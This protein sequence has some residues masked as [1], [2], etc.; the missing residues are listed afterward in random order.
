M[1]REPRRSRRLPRRRSRPLLLVVCGSER[2]EA[3]YF[4]GLRDSGVTRAIDI[5]IVCR[6]KAP[7]QVVAYAH[8]YERNARRDFDQVWCV[9][10]V[11]DYDLG[12]ADRL[13]GRVGILLAMSNPCFELWLLL[14]HEDCRAYQ[15]DY[16][17]VAR[18]LRR[19]VAAYDKARLDFRD[20]RD[21]LADAITRAK[22][23][24]P[25]GTRYETNPSSGM[26]RLV[27]RIME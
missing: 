24:D 17:A 22:G 2:T 5:K 10:D 12:E 8:E 1:S 7:A 11:D 26:W 6:P 3:Q 27:E 25:T 21:G 16:H 19:Y 9:F 15:A 18:R 13:A 4:D 14:H 20:Y 23:L